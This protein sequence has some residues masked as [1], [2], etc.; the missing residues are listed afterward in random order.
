MAGLERTAG[1]SA[2][3]LLNLEG[4]ATAV[5]AVAAFREKGGYRLWTALAAM[6]LA[7]V[8]LSYSPGGAAFGE[9]SLLIILAMVCWG[10][11][12]NLMQKVSDHDAVQ[13]AMI[14]SACAAVTSLTLAMVFFGGVRMAVPTLAA[15]TIGVACYG[16]SLALFMI[17]LR[18]L[19]SSRTGTFFSVGPYV[20]AMAAIPLL[21]EGVTVQLLIAGGLM[22]FG[23]WLITS[24]GHEHEHRHEAVEHDHVHSHGDGAHDHGGEGTHAHLHVHEAIVHSHAHWPDSGHRHEHE[25]TTEKKG[26]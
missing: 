9:G 14:K 18:H 16:A 21:G 6:T 24:E 1:S 20:A 4:V 22:L 12:N 3:L 5:I 25:T 11:D 2:S 13:L 8:F 15:I 7:S 17:G 23:T 26:R 10:I 19:G